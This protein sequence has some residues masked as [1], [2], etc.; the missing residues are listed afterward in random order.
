MIGGGNRSIPKKSSALQ[1]TI[2]DKLQ[3]MEFK[4][5]KGTDECCFDTLQCAI[6]L[7]QLNKE[8]SISVTSTDQNKE[9]P[10]SNQLQPEDKF[11]RFLK[12]LQD[13]FIQFGD[14]QK[15]THY[16]DDLLTVNSN[17]VVQLKCHEKHVFHY[18]CFTMYIKNMLRA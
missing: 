6:C 4:D 15:R 5:L 18:N 12:N 16:T 1:K 7:G 2:L 17:K 8:V 9:E 14:D 11:V 13:G 10:M 3:P